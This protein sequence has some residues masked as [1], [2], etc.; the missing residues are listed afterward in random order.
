VTPKATRHSAAWL[1]LTDETMLITPGSRKNKATPYAW[2]RRRASSWR[3]R[4]LSS[5]TTHQS[6]SSVNETVATDW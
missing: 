1:L 5:S 2:R 4:D 6:P 3:S